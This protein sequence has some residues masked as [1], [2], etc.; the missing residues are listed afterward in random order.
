ML[1]AMNDLKDIENIRLILVGDNFACEPFISDIKA[2]GMHDKIIQTGFRSDVP[3]IAKACDVLVLPSEREGL[4]RVVL[5]S[6]AVGTPVIT[7]SNEGAM[8]IIEDKIN[9]YVVPIGDGKAIANRIRLLI[10]NTALLQQLSDN[11]QKT[12]ATNMSHDK[13]VQDMESYFQG[14]LQD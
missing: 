7:S 9:G 4:P 2:T 8:E 3:Q 10:E 11:A 12:I 6:L 14:M 5:E 13:T 1:D